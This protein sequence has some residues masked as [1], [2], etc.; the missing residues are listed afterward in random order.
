S[1]ISQLKGGSETF[2]LSFSLILCQSI[3]NIKISKN[4]LFK[5]IFSNRKIKNS[6]ILVINKALLVFNMEDKE[7]RKLQKTRL[8]IEKNC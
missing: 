1:N 5:E 8:L 7:E 3:S 4:K 2:I 6:V